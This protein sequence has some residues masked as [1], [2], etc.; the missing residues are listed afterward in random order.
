MARNICSMEYRRIV[1]TA[2]PYDRHAS[3]ERNDAIE[4]GKFGKGRVEH[5]ESTC[6]TV[7]FLDGSERRLV[8]RQPA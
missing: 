2:R 8:H 7:Q 3:Y 6:I 1:Q 5:S 4:H